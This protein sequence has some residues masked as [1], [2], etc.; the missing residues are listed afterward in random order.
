MME[1]A[2]LRAEALAVALARSD[3]LEGEVRQQQQQL[4]QLTERMAAMD[5]QDINQRLPILKKML[6]VDTVSSH[7]RY[8]HSYYYYY[9]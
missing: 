6:G 3:Q 9:Y 5:S 2:S 1:M 4:Q 7:D 8:A